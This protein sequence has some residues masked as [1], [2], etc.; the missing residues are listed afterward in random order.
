MMSL[1]QLRKGQEWKSLWKELADGSIEIYK[2]IK[3]QKD[4]ICSLLFKVALILN[5]EKDVYKNLFQKT[6]MD[7]PL[8]D[9]LEDKLKAI[10]L[11]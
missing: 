11:K 3:I 7:M 1:R 2:P 4:K 6:Q 8:E 5:S 9:L 10:S